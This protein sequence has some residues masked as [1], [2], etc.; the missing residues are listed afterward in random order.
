MWQSAVITGD[1]DVV[2]EAQGFA[3]KTVAGYQEIKNIDPSTDHDVNGVTKIFKQ[4]FSSAKKLTLEIIEG[5]ISAG[6]LK[7]RATDLAKSLKDYE[8]TL[9]N[10]RKM[11]Y[12]QF[13]AEL[14]SADRDSQHNLLWGLVLGVTIMLTLG[15]TAFAI[16][17]TISGGVNK[18]MN[19]MGGMAK[20][21]LTTHIEHSGNDEIG[22]LVKYHNACASEMQGLIKEIVDSVIQFSALSDRLLSAMKQTSD[23]VDQQHMETDQLATAITEMAATVTE[24]A[25]NTNEAAKAT[26]VADAEANEGLKVMTATGES[27]QRLAGDVEDAATAIQSLEDD[28]KNIGTVLDVIKAIAEQTN[29]LALNAAIE[30][31]RAGEQGRGFA[32]VAD[33]VRNLASRTQESTLE[34]E[35][36]IDKLQLGARNAVKVMEKGRSQAQDSVEKANSAGQ[37]LGNITSA[38]NTMADMNTQIATAA[39]QQSSVAEEI[40]RNIE[41]INVLANQTANHALES[42]NNVSEMALLAEHLGGLVS[43]FKVR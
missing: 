27:I 1:E 42:S 12:E 43:R 11:Q 30:A 32:V 31:A 6:D 19:A 4:Y 40:N 18:V 5:D 34:I 14:D 17:R 35:A 23:S 3:N 33:E 16:G 8:S 37:L 26:Q 28:S 7:V 9:H 24:V 20:G 38:V 29:L 39:E 15:I 13:N 36:T 10:F 22:K 21:N 2:E 41:G 25:R